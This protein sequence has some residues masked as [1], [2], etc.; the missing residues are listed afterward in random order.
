MKRRALAFPFAVLTLATACSDRSPLAPTPPDAAIVDSRTNG[1]AFPGFYFLFPI[2]RLSEERDPV[3]VF[4]PDVSPVIKVWD[5]GVTTD[6]EATQGSWTEL[7]ILTMGARLLNDIHVLRDHDEYVVLW[8]TRPLDL[9]SNRTYRIQVFAGSQLLGY[10]DVDVVRRFRDLGSVDREEYVPLLEDLILPIRFWIGEEAFCTGT[11]KTTTVNFPPPAG[12]TS[13]PLSTPTGEEIRVDFAEGTTVETGGN[14]V[15]QVNFT[16]EACDGIDVDLPKF[17][18]CVRLTA[19]FVADEGET[20]SWLRFVNHPALVTMCLLDPEQ[21]HAL[22]HEQ[23]HL[24]TLHQQDGDLVRA[25]PHASESANCPSEVIPSRRYGARGWR[26]LRDVALGFFTPQTLHARSRTVVFNIGGGGQTHLLGA[27][28]G[29]RGSVNAPRPRGLFLAEVCS[30]PPAV[31]PVLAPPPPQSGQT[32]SDFQFAMPA[33]MDYSNSEDAGGLS[34]VV[35]STLTFSVDLTDARGGPVPSG[36]VPA[37]VTF[38]V[39]DG[40]STVG[41]PANVTVT[42]GVAEFIWP[43]VAGTFTITASARGIASPDNNGPLTPPD[44]DGEGPISDF[45]PFWPDFDVAAIASRDDIEAET[46]EITFTA[47][48]TAS[49]EGAWQDAG[50]LEPGRRDHTATLLADGDVL[51]VGGTAS[52]AFF[53]NADAGSL[54]A[55][56]APPLFNHGQHATATRLGD[57]R[58]LIVGGLGAPFSAEI[59]DHSNGSFTATAGGVTEGATNASRIAHSATLL[60]DG[61]VLLVGGQTQDGPT[62]THP[63][64]EIY[65]PETDAFT[66]VGSLNEDRSSHSAALISGGRVLIVGGTQTTEPGF[67]ACLSS[68]ELFDPES[69]TFSTTGGMATGRCDLLW[70]NAS[71]LV[72]GLVLVVGGSSTS[73]ELYNP[74]TGSFSLTGGMASLH[75]AGSSTSL[76]DGRVLVA[77]GVVA[78]G[79]Q[80]ATNTSAAEIF[81]PT[82][83]IFTPATSMSIPRQQHTATR[84]ADGRVLVFG[85]HS[86][87]AVP[88]CSDVSSAE[89]FSRGP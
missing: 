14:T 63:E 88:T 9:Q 41:A 16:A 64:A 38:T 78:G 5:C 79:V 10:A 12:G 86:T 17:G 65:D 84:L 34:G 37:Q 76:A 46:A 68:A 44:P 15:S 35:G 69:E 6:C 77:G 81:N 31:S 4:N 23:A 26:W 11:C 8:N 58:V 25:L 51:V 54:L 80:C 30:T 3:G 72:S 71:V 89:V 82:L 56:E 87:T 24:I 49:L 66:P 57:G 85:G 45:D 22:A 32:I 1:S 67:G 53:Y 36:D 21:E 33:K 70:N 40:E 39:S 73:A 74:A 52:G 50:S 61:R 18:D 48:G 2:R 59:Y 47:T 75:S 20:A 60:S 29:S 28:C 7:Q 43:V 55:T 62:E 13:I 19:D 42:N 27:V 83:G